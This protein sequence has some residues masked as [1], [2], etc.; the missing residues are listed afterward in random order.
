MRFIDAHRERR[1]DGL[2]WGAELLLSSIKSEDATFQ[3]PVEV[4]SKVAL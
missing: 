1:T 3:D 2:A 4:T